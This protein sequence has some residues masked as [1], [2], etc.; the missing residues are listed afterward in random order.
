MV[1]CA[2]IV[3]SNNY[4]DAQSPHLSHFFGILSAEEGRCLTRWRYADIALFDMSE[5]RVIQANE[6]LVSYGGV[7]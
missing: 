3:A 7:G 5:G 6:M 1:F 2:S 4:R